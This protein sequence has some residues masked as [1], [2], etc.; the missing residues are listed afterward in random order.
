M[1]KELVRHLCAIAVGLGLQFSL[2]QQHESGRRTWFFVMACTTVAGLIQ[3]VFF[4]KRNKKITLPMGVAMVISHAIVATV[5]MLIVEK[6]YHPQI[7]FLS[8]QLLNN[9]EIGMLF[10]GGW[11]VGLLSV[12]S[13]FL[14]YKNKAD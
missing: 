6:I 4:K 11:I 3:I 13:F 5:A 1:N 8:K 7:D 10:T 9:F 12:V 2:L 14:S